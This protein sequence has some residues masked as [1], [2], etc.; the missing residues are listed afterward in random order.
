MGRDRGSERLR[1]FAETGEDALRR[2]FQRVERRDATGEVVFRDADAVRGYIA[3]SVSHKHLAE[4]V[5]EFDGPLH[6]TRRNAIFVAER[7]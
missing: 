1:F 4:L 5:P 6:A 2:H 7:A 3:S